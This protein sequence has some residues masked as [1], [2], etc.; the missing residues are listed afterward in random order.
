MF[1]KHS[2]IRRQCLHRFGFSSFLS[3]LLELPIWPVQTQMSLLNV[4]WRKSQ[5]LSRAHRHGRLSYDAAF[6][7]RRQ[8][9]LVSLPRRNI[10]LGGTIT[11]FTT[12][13]R[14]TVGACR[15]RFTCRYALTENTYNAKT[16]PDKPSHLEPR[17]HC[18]FSR[19]IGD[20]TTL[21]RF[22]SVK[23]QAKPL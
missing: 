14:F 6:S 19:E 17:G 4:S 22:S 16:S 5:W 8:P 12:G 9:P 2:L 11:W 20:V 7:R 3:F 10:V 23:K 1:V 13:A 21:K 15:H 18:H